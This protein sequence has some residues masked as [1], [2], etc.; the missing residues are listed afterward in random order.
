MKTK[1]LKTF[2]IIVIVSFITIS[3][4]KSVDEVAPEPINISGT[5]S[6]GLS[7]QGA[8]NG[9]LANEPIPTAVLIS[10][11]NTNGQVI[12]NLEKL[13]LVEVN[14]SFVS[15][16]IELDTGSYTVEDFIV[17]D[18]N[19]TSVYITPKKG[20]EFEGLVSTPLPYAFHVEPDETTTVEL[21]V[22]SSKLGQAS[23]F[24]Y[25]EFTFNNV[26][27][28]EAGLVAHYPL[29]G[30]A[31]DESGN[32]FDGTVFGASS[33]EDRNGN[34]D[35]AYLFDGVDDNINFGDVSDLGSS[36]F[37]ISL[38]TSVGEFKGPIE[39]TSSAGAWMIAKGITIAGTPPRAGFAL[40][41]E[42]FDEENYFQFSIGGETNQVFTTRDFENFQEDTWYHVIGRR[43]SDK[44]E[45]YVNGEL[46]SEATVPLGLDTDTNIPLSLGRIDKLGFDPVGTT[47]FNGVIDEVR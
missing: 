6:F 42:K 14:G 20:S 40:R 29:N 47:Y 4:K 9:K 45:L 10:I 19:D 13:T 43:I 39:G 22:V 26:V 17:T 15:S 30:N 36:D 24:G 33:V 7:V 34:H 21:D 23:D 41:A 11:K 5:L 35:S 31:D 1:Y 32:E 27:D 46:L 28:L 18:T 3:C 2:L 16:T 8:D 37:T 12:Y 38:W 25:A 44:I